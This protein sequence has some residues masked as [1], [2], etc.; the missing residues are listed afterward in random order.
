MDT[1]MIVALLILQPVGLNSVWHAFT[2][3]AEHFNPHLHAG[4][5]CDHCLEVEQ[6]LQ[7][8]LGNLCLVGRVLR[9]PSRVLQQVALN[10]WGKVGV[11]VAQ[12]QIGLE[13][14]VLLC[15]CPAGAGRAS[16]MQAMIWKVLRCN[17]GLK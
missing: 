12:S 2:C 1:C 15:N 10:D 13:D 9:V 16:R 14:L 5:V 6:R 4:E 11:V 3:P 7:A 8:P 17:L